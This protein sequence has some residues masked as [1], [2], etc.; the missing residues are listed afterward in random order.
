VR[1]GATQP[2]AHARY[3]ISAFSL[4]GSLVWPWVYHDLFFAQLLATHL[5]KAIHASTVHVVQLREGA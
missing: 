3:R 5:R 1:C 2:G 4:S